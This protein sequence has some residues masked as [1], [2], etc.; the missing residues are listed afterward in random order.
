MLLAGLA[1]GAL[2]LRAR[3]WQG[4]RVPAWVKG[5]GAVVALLLAAWGLQR[6]WGPLDL[7]DGILVSTEAFALRLGL[8]GAAFGLF[9]LAGPR[10]GRPAAP[11]H[12]RVVWIAVALLLGGAA[13]CDRPSPRRAAAGRRRRTGR[14]PCWTRAGCGRGSPWSRWC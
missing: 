5:A 12:D 10:K 6:L 3:E 14:H 9:C 13:L 11:P 2:G 4:D 7:A 8:T 1:V